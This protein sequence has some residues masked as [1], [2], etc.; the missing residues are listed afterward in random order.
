[1]HTVRRRTRQGLGTTDRMTHSQ[2][3]RGRIQVYKRVSLAHRKAKSFEETLTRRPGIVLIVVGLGGFL[4]SM[5]SGRWYRPRIPST[6][7]GNHASTRSL[8]H[9]RVGCLRVELPCPLV[10]RSRGI[11]VWEVGYRL[12]VYSRHRWHWQLTEYKKKR[13]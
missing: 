11:R 12:R 1:M 4:W 8:D 10:S 9:R 6:L 3:G 5:S 7:H 2:E 13:N